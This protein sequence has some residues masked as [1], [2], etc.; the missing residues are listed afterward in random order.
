MK[1]VLTEEEQDF[2]IKNHD[3]IYKFLNSQRLDIETY[4]DV[5]VFGYL[6][7]VRD[8]CRKQS[9]RKYTFSACATRSMNDCLFKFWRA[10]SAQMRKPDAPVISLDAD[11]SNGENKTMRL[12]DVVA[13]KNNLIDDYV[14]AESI[15]GL[16]AGCTDIQRAIA[17]MIM[18][19]SKQSR[20]IKELNISRRIYLSEISK[21]RTLFI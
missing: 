4:Y 9:A 5:V 8:Y 12:A 3:N 16:L 20:I 17:I 2:A 15:K 13:D 7:A 21:I 18:N 14:Q 19:G 10:E 6:K 1:Y 11:I